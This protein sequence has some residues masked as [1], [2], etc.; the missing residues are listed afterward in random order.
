MEISFRGQAAS[1]RATS[2]RARRIAV[3]ALASIAMDC[4]RQVKLLVTGGLGQK[5][6]NTT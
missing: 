3:G 4:S 5:R 1:P 6:R 2:R